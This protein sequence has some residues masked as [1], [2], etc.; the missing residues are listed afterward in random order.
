MT[1]PIFTRGTSEHGDNVVGE[2]YYHWKWEE[3]CGGRIEASAK[4]LGEA[5]HVLG[6]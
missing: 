4:A 1:Q 6:R 3:I 2:S 5:M